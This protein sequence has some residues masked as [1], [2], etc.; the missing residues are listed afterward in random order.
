MTS[1]LQGLGFADPARPIAIGDVL[2][3]EMASGRNRD[4]RKIDANS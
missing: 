1:M 4:Q 3:R 2:A